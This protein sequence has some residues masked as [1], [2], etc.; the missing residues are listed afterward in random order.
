MPRTILLVEDDEAL[1]YTIAAHL[2]PAGF[3][4][5]AVGDALAALEQLDGWRFDL[6]L[7][8]V[9]LP[10]GGP[11]G[12]SLANM[13]K[14]R[15]GMPVIFITGYRELLEAQKFVPG[16]VFQKPLDLEA[17]T[18]E[19]ARELATTPLPL[20]SMAS[21][22]DPVRIRRWRQKAE[23]LR[24]A[25]DSFDDGAARANMRSAATTYESLADSAE[26]RR[27]PT[28]KPKPEAG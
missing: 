21:P 8:D 5:V 16:K 18:L 12:L 7:V 9:Q 24:T 17:L 14:R 6:L 23:E 11:H 3:I 2:T 10:R 25:S 27:E 19:I 20:P 15:Q 26:A 28:K 13:A 1:R 22:D 4:V